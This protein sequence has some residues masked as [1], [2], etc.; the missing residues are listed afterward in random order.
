MNSIISLLFN[1]IISI[2]R[3][4]VSAESANQFGELVADPVTNELLHY[5]EKPETFVRSFAYIYLL[6][7]IFLCFWCFFIWWIDLWGSFLPCSLYL[8]GLILVLYVGKWPNKLWRIHL[9]PR[10]LYC[11]P[12]GFHSA[13]RQRSVIQI[14]D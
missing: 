4:Q 7:N 2:L 11:H 3:V 10:Y 12:G 9:Y 6:F 14:F 8:S 5:T 1:V 13:Q